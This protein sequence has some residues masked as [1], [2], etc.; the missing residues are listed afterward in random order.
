M[1]QYS[2]SLFISY[3][4]S[5]QAQWTEN[6][7]DIVSAAIQYL[8]HIRVSYRLFL[9]D[10][11]HTDLCVFLRVD[12]AVLSVFCLWVWV[13]WVFFISVWGTLMNCFP[14]RICDFEKWVRYWYLNRKK[15]RLAATISW[16]S[17]TCFRLQTKM[18][19]D[20]LP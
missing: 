16:F 2:V 14:K 11:S 10:T 15:L 9:H 19:P 7:W 20:I 8:I 5:S 13:N 1:N 17:H 3:H 18:S 4:F 12:V 6:V